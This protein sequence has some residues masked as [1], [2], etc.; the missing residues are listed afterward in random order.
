MNPEEISEA[1]NST[2]LE[3]SLNCKPEKDQFEELKI[4]N[5]KPNPSCFSYN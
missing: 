1:D 5:G 3:N 2:N 4:T